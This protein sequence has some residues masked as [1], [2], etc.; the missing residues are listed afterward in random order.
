M[1]RDTRSRP[2]GP[3]SRG[4]IRPWGHARTARP[5]GGA[6]QAGRSEWRSS[7]VCAE[8]A[9]GGATATASSAWM[10][11]RAAGRR[12]RRVTC[13]PVAAEVEADF[14]STDEDDVDADEPD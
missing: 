13:T 14:Q 2:H 4:G 8:V 11:A 7:H 10:N 5:A 9:P 3:R 6:W 12:A 1:V